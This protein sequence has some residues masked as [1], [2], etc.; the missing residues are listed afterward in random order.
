MLRRS[1]VGIPEKGRGDDEYFRALWQAS[2]SSSHNGILLLQWRWVRQYGFGL[3]L[4]LGAVH[5]V[6]SRR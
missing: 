4:S 1:G 5:D 2:R 3:Q 6:I